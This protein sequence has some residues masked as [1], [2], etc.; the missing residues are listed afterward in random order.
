MS[1]K[2]GDGQRGYRL[3]GKWSE[4]GPKRWAGPRTREL[5]SHSESASD[6]TCDGVEVGEL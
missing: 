5:R 3:M 2:E 1:E 4:M 6:F